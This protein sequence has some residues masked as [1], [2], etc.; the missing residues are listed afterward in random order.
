MH[1]LPPLRIKSFGK[2]EQKNACK[3]FTTDLQVL[4][5]S[6]NKNGPNFNLKT[7][8]KS[9]T[10]KNLVYLIGFL[11]A[12]TF[13]QRTLAQQTVSDQKNLALEDT[14]R[15]HLQQAQTLVRQG[16][17]EEASKILTNIMATNPNNK[18]AVQWWLIAN[19]K[20]SPSGEVDAIPMLDSL[21]KS[22]PANTG[23]LF[24]KIFIQAEHGMNQEALAN[25]EKLISVQP[26]SADNWILK[27]QILQGLEKN[28]EACAAFD[29]AIKLNPARTDVYGMKAASLIKIGK[30]DEAL[31]NV[32]K[33]IE[34]SPNDANT[35]Y[36][37]ACI[38]S[39]SGDKKKALSDLKKAIEM[40][41]EL[42]KYAPTDSDLKSLYE[43]EEFKE[44]TK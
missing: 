10:M 30:L 19:M 6:N 13:S 39:L 18:E 41:P 35:V 44:L 16:K 17:K 22:Y 8:L 3:Y 15:V 33:A 42:K 24:F 20:R 1:S 32:N 37:R 43:D 14:L 7:I 26:D 34:L 38:Y 27:G 40:N 11:V 12:V 4:F 23:I 36:N 25:V 21:S 5:N 28:K 29:K 9:K 2:L 31:T